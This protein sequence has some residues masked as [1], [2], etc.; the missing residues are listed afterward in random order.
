[1]IEGVAIAPNNE[2]E[3]ALTVQMAATHAASMSVLSRLGGGGS[4]DRRVT[5][6]ASA[7]A[8]LLQAYT[9]QVERLRRLRHGG[10]QLLRVEHV[11]IDE[12]AQ[13]IIGNVN[14]K[15]D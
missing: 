3:A 6:L 7:A 8:R 5:A 14:K 9:T 15:K 4:G 11:R 13:A 12:G 1:M 2:I 10:S